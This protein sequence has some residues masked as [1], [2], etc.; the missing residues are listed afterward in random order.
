MNEEVSRDM[1]DEAI[2][3]PDIS[4]LVFFHFLFIVYLVYDFIINIFLD[5]DRKD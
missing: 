5:S 1:T 2:L 4:I 3:S